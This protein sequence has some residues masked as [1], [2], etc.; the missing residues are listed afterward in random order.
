MAVVCLL[1]IAGRGAGAQGAPEAAG[2]HVWEFIVRDF[3]ED[4]FEFVEDI[5]D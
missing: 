3:A 5:F 2:A 4:A 1:G